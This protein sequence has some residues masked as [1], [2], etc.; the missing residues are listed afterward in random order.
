MAE[1][2]AKTYC[3]FINDSITLRFYDKYCL[4]NNA[5]L[6]G[7]DGTLFSGFICNNCGYA[8]IVQ[9]IINAEKRFIP[10]VTQQKVTDKI[11]NFTST[12]DFTFTGDGVLTDKETVSGDISTKTQYSDFIKRT[13]DGLVAYLPQTMRVTNSRAGQSDYIFE[14]SYIYDSKHSPP[15]V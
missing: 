13:A 12:T 5:T 8:N 6:F 1:Y 15:K 4:A 11:R 10:V 14:S 3:N 9:G 2:Q 7:I